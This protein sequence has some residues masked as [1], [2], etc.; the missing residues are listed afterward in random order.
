M[1]L[2]TS[3]VVAVLQLEPEAEQF[4]GLIESVPDVRISAATV[5]EA[6][7]VLGRS[8]QRLLDQFLEEAGAVVVPVDE[9]QLAIARE[10]HLRFGRGS[11]ATARLNYGDCFSYACAIALDEPLLFK[12]DDFGQTDVLDARPGD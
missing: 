9:R 1:I 6:S 5:L 11:G 12:G 7:L 10:A 4:A 8:R 3:A 2:D